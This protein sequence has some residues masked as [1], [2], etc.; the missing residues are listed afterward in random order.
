MITK[1]NIIIGAGPAGLQLAYYFEKEKIEYLVLERSGAAGSFFSKF[2]HSDKL[3]SINKKYTGTSHKEFNLRHDW[4]SLI[5]EKVFF[6]DYSENY[7]PDRAELVRYLNDF[8]DEHELKIQYGATVLKVKRDKEGRYLIDTE[9][10]TN[11]E[12]NGVSGKQSKTKQSYI[13]EK[14]I[15]ATGMSVPVKPAWAV[16]TVDSVRHYG[17]YVA[18]WFKKKENLDELKGRSVLIVGNG[19]SGLE[20]SNLLTP[21]CSKILLLGRSRKDWSATSH[22]TGDVRSVYLPFIDTF[23]LKSLGAMDTLHELPGAAEGA[24][25]W[26]KQEVAGGPY[27]FGVRCS[28]ACEVHHPYYAAGT[29]E[30]DKV[31]FC[32]GWKFDSSIFSFDLETVAGGKYPQMSPHYESTNNKGL[33]FVGSLM[34]PYDYKKSSGGFIHGFRYLIRNFVN[35]VYKVPFEMQEFINVGE[36]IDHVMLRINTSSALYQMYGQLVDFFYFDIE[37]KKLKYYLGVN[38]QFLLGNYFKLKTDLV[39]VVSLEYGDT[40]ITDYKKMGLLESSIGNENKSTLLHPV[41]RVI[42]YDEKNGLKHNNMRLEKHPA[43]VE[44]FHFDEDLFAE[45]GDRQKYRAK[46]DRC[47][48]IFFR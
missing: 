14:L 11:Y 5:N 34:H 2:P 47:L 33:Y 42:E 4:N 18:G 17:E 40:T 9:V 39:F 22:Y 26:I 36:M 3:I 31:I 16:D 43:L 32:T 44:E 20:L 13:C 35:A 10:V 48:S 28:K 25:Y 38:K 7:Y 1:K 27:S 23:L 8:S 45:Y 37:E 41:L 15:M 12:G 29:T 19:N 30:F 24:K 6:P 21:Y 46:L